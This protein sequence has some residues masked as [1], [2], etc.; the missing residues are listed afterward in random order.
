VCE[1]AQIGIIVYQIILILGASCCGGAVLAGGR[2][3]VGEKEGNPMDAH[4][5]GEGF[6]S[7]VPELFLHVAR[8]T[9]AG[10]GVMILAGALAAQ[11][12]VRPVSIEKLPKSE[13]GRI[14]GR[15]L[16]TGLG[17]LLLRLLLTPLLLLPGLV[18]RLL[19]L[20]L[21]LLPAGA[22]G[23]G[24]SSD[25]GTLRLVHLRKISLALVGEEDICQI[26]DGVV[27]LR[28]LHNDDIVLATHKV[29]MFADGDTD[30]LQEG[31]FVHI[32]ERHLTSKGNN[33][34]KATGGPIPGGCLV[35][36]AL[37][38][39]IAHLVGRLDERL[40]D[41]VVYFKEKSHGRS[42]FKIKGDIHVHVAG[43]H[44][45][46]EKPDG[47]DVDVDD[48]LSPYGRCLDASFRVAAEESW[49]QPVLSE[50]DPD[51]VIDDALRLLEERV[52]PRAASRIQAGSELRG[53]F[54]V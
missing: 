25:I 36:E 37:V 43:V 46:A 15:T 41:L 52:E 26:R 6:M 39:D 47:T 42:G 33:G 32:I 5:L 11:S 8:A 18:L 22:W 14:G 20:L 35:L 9:G 10:A 48:I 7:E 30:G 44:D 2:G 27:D 51:A 13:R 38:H 49:L 24:I 29:V 12:A 3:D 21:L 34:S 40:D 1:H 31:I 28:I 19:L 45:G 50:I 54:E 53:T 23:W 4:V 17:G 16:L